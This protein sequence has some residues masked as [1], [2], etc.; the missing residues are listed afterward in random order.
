M[1]QTEISID[2]TELDFESA[3]DIALVIAGKENP[4]PFLISW[5]DKKNNTHSPP[6][7]K[8]EIKGKPGWEVYGENHG[9]RLRISINS[10]E[11]VFI[12][13]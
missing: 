5:C 12:Y 11:Y 3:R 1:Q 8:C 2:N 10:D 4:D 9:G 13:G 7:V 6:S